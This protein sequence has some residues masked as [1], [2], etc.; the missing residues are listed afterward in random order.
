M[1]RNIF[2]TNMAL[3]GLIIILDLLYMF[4]GGLWLKSITSFVFV[5]CGGVNLWFAYKN[6]LDL[7]FPIILT[8]ALFVA[9][10][11]DIVI[12]IEFMAGAIIFAVGHIFYFVAYCTLYK[13]SPSDLVYAFAIAIPSM[14]IVLFAP[15]LDYGG[16]MMKVVCCVYALI[17]S[18]MVGKALANML[19]EKS[20]TNI[21]I[22][23]GS[24]LFF[25]SD[26]MLLLDVFGNIAGT[27]FACLATYYPGQIVI[28][29]GSYL[30]ASN[31]GKKVENTKILEQKEE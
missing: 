15:G 25:I 6:K 8:V 4:L 30:W 2:I 16:T 14:L 17:I 12:N 13:V 21:I 9:M 19:K 26:L 5:A 7:K 18:C 28:A 3:A 20:L 11:G 24:V 22:L 29:F 10:L 31:S 1:K 23:V 27:G